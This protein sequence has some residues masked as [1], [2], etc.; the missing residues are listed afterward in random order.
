MPLAGAVV[1]LVIGVCGYLFPESRADVVMLFGTGFIFPLALLIGR[2]RRENLTDRLNPL[3]RLMGL[4][5]LM[6]NLLWAVHLPLLMQAPKFFPLSLGIGLGIHWI[7]YSWII[8]HPVGVIHAVARTALVV[9]TWFAVPDSRMF[10]IPVAIVI[11][12]LFSLVVMVRRPIASTRESD[13]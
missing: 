1:W 13:A 7:A 11:V 12:Y 8:Q 6:V 9:A 2:F 4:S 10:A 3:S 5:V